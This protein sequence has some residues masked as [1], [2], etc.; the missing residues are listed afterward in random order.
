MGIKLFVKN[1]SPTEQ[2]DLM[3]FLQY[4]IEV[5]KFELL[6]NSSKIISKIECPNCD[7]LKVVGHGTYKGRGQYIYVNQTLY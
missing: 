5:P 1:L 2:S 7:D 4:E 3:K 6:N